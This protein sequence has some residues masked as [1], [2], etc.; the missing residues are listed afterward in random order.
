LREIL[1]GIA[2]LIFPPL[3][4]TCGTVL[5]KHTPL[6]FCL[7]CTAGIHVIHSPLCP[8][9]GVPFP[10]TEGEDHLCGECLTTERPYA[11]ARAVGLY[12]G[13]L[14]T[15]IHLLKYREES[16]SVRSWGESWLILPA[17]NGI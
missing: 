3:C 6:P 2:D 7:P 4:I 8:R 9:C 16:G 5:E 14:L 13:T 17:V 12:E 1:T 15:A 10:A 11:V